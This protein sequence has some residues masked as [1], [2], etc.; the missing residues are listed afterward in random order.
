MI[1]RVTNDKQIMKYIAVLAKL[2]FD[3]I[4]NENHS[5]HEN[6][7]YSCRIGCIAYVRYLIFY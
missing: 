3:D 4:W 2:F 1:K 6:E 5:K 7:K